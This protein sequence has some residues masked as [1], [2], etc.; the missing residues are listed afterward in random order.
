MAATQSIGQALFDSN[1]KPIFTAPIL[2]GSGKAVTGSDGQALFNKV[3]TMSNGGALANL[4]LEF[5]A[6]F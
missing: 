3:N 4:D 1:G 6:T 5:I 2:D